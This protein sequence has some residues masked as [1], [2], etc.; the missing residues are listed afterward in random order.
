MDKV[1]FDGRNRGFFIDIGANH[2][3]KLSNTLYFECLG[4]DGIAFEPQSK[5]CALWKERKTKCYNLALGNK[6]C[7]L[8]FAEYEGDDEWNTLAGAA[9]VLGKSASGKRYPVRQR[10]LGNILKE[11]GIKSVDFVSIDVE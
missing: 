7:E 6:E 8:E 9:S 4:W 3:S 1:I 10:R 5:L 11:M 2:P